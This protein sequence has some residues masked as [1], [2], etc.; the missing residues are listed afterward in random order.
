MLD[1]L[2]DKSACILLYDH[3]LKDIATFVKSPL[4]IEAFEHLIQ[5]FLLS[6]QVLNLKGTCVI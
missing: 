4:L 2:S 6:P 1:S 5:L 3:K